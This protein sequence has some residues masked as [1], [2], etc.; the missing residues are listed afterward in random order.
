MV[1]S[2]DASKDEGT[3][4]V[5][6][7]GA[8]I[9]PGLIAK[10]FDPLVQDSRTIHRSRG[11]LGLGL[12]VV[13]GLVARLG[14]SVSAASD[15]PG[16]GSIF[17]CTS[18]AAPA[19]PIPQSGGPA[20][21][22]CGVPSPQESRVTSR[23][24]LASWRF[25]SFTAVQHACPVAG[26]TRRLVAVLGVIGLCAGNVAVCAGWR[27]TPE[28][29]MACCQD[30]ASCPMHKSESHGSQS[31]QHVTQAQADNCC[32]G[33]ERNRLGHDSHLVRSRQASIVALVPASHSSRRDA[34]A[35]RAPGVACPRSAASLARPE[36]P[37]ALRLP[38]LA[39]TVV[40]CLPGSVSGLVVACAVCVARQDECLRMINRLIELSLRNR[41]IVIA[42]YLGLAGWGWW[43]LTATPIDAIPDLSDNQVIVFTD[44]AGHSPQ[45]V[46][47]QVTYPLTAN[48]QGLAGVRVV[49]SQSAFGFSMIYVVFEDNVD[50]Y[51]A[52]ARVL[53]R[54]SLDHEDAAR[55]AS[56]RRS[57]RM[58]P[59]SATCSGTRSRARRIHSA[60]CARC[61]TGSSAISSIPCRA[62]R[63]SP[64]S[65]AMSSSTR[66]TSI[67]T[68]SGPTTCRSARWCRPSAPAT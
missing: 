9:A 56:R 57:D 10:I 35:A 14:G 63:K 29:R 11:G 45:E 34:A 5:R 49:R 32:A 36:A 38:R 31:E 17:T 16:C 13:Q 30:E 55:P 3:I 12:F 33:S 67:R 68:V 60:I 18:A 61:R 59:A 27:A 48:L 54:M 7:D 62:S 53:E 65:A 41:F 15:G 43:A 23:R 8:G 26:M 64:P 28:A 39:K 66:S 50:L 51:F 46:E 2:V 42:L 52:R 37:P 19:A 22:T 40:V 44:W 20:A 1:L 58:R 25:D 21:G 6:D 47:D 24:T 4:E